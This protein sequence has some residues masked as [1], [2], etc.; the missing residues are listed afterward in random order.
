MKPDRD[1][2]GEESVILSGIH[3]VN[4]LGVLR[5]FRRK[6]IPV[7]LLDVDPHSMVRYSRF[8]SR[9]VPCPNPNDSE[10]GFVDALVE[11]GR[12]LDHQPVFIPTGDAEVMA[13]A[14]HEDVLLPYFRMPVASFDTIDLLVN[15]KRFFRDVIRRNIPCPRTCFP[16]TVT[17]MRAMATDIGYPLII[18][19]AYS[20]RFIREFHKKVFV[21]HSPSALETAIGLINGAYQDYFLQE[22]IPGNTLY[23]FYSYFN[24]Q[25]VP[26]GIC[27]YD[28]VR[29]FPKDFGIGTICRS[30]NRSQ[31]IQAA[32]EY[33]Q[34]IGYYGLA[35]PEFKLDPRDG[36]YKLIEINTRAVTMTLLAKACGVH[37]EY[38]AYLD[39]ISRN[40]EPL[41]PATEGIVWIDEINELHYQLSRIRRGHFS[42]AELREMSKGKK[43]FACAAWDDPVPLIIGLAHFFYE[44]FKSSGEADTMLG[45]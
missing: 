9:R 23:L 14:R 27:G 43:I 44:R 20:H 1:H 38:L 18:K 4:A 37:V 13:L 17:E 29:Q 22:I 16:E 8:V 21:I 6:G 32:V 39:L 35:E 33:L 34:S 12:S 42:F 41:G 31:P 25:S 3:N 11:L 5:G 45:I 2:F 7:I 28:K 24:H 10:T 26:L 30:M 15:K 19:S 36:L 40:V